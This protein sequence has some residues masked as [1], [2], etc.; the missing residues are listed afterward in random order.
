MIKVYII[1]D[2]ALIR[3]RLKYVIA[4]IPDAELTGE[5]GDSLIAVTAFKEMDPDVVIL[6][7]RMPGKT[8]IELLREIKKLKPS[9]IGIIL[10]NYFYPQYRERYLDAGA[11]Y[12]LNKSTEFEKISDIIRTII[13]DSRTIGD[14]R[15]VD[16]EH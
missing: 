14:D 2:S 12:F 13:L 5:T 16:R 9:V 6:D 1:D 4:D 15:H 3:E 8:G 10:S 11:D 7:I